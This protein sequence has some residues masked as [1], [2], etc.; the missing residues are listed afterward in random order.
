MHLGRTVREAR[1]AKG[2]S[3]GDLARLVGTSQQNVDRIE[4]SAVVHSRSLPAILKALGLSEATIEKGKTV[5]LLGYVGAGAQM[6]SFDVHAGDE[7]LEEVE[8]P[9][10]ATDTTVAVQVRGDSMEPAYQD[11]D[12][13]Y[14]D[15]QENG[16]L[17]H[18]VGKDCVVRLGDGRTYVKQLR[19]TNG[20]YWLHSHNADPM[21]GVQI[22]WAA[23]VKWVHKA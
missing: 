2:L 9:F 8:K 10:G 14:Y 16:G 7:S 12:L 4:R 3:Q 5:P 23:K 13:L 21:L 11:G 19:R 22:V 20:Q 6:F 17:E 1:E 18:L 15:Q